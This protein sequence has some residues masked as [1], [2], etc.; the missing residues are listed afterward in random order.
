MTDTSYFHKTVLIFISACIILFTA[1]APII[2]AEEPVALKHDRNTLELKWQERIQS[3]LNTG[4]IP[5]ID[6]ESS[7]KREDGERYIPRAINVM[8]KSGIALIAFDGYQ[9]PKTSKKQKGYRWGY[10]IHHIVNSYPDRFILATNGDTNNN[11]LKQKDSFVDQT[12]EHVKSGNYPIMGEFDFRHYMSNHQCKKGNT[13]RDTNIPI[14]GENA[15]LIFSLSEK[16]GIAFT[17][18]HEPEDRPLAELEEM[19][20]A[21]PKA[22]VIWA[23]FGQIRFPKNETR[24]N[25][26]LVRRLLSSY[27][28]LYFDISTGQPG[29]SYKCNSNVLDTVIW[30]KNS[31]GS[32]KDTL[33]PEYKDIL[34]EFSTRFVVGTDY[35]G[36]R[37]PL[38]DFLKKRVKNARLIMRD[39]TEEA[40]HNISYRNAWFLL[41]GKE[42]VKTTPPKA[43]QLH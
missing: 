42:W 22:K 35:G 29:R 33:K 34:N 26:E 8:D 10:Y 9:A 16:M 4:V 13:K 7:L 21:Y 12:G 19:L 5:L 39:L 3:F 36:G 41:T 27:P 37:S 25:P 28:G 17:I 20:A 31:F 40:K 14:N 43:N 23:H 24:F 6:L 38:P 18:H 30:N 11:W 15:H 32:Q 1:T 2:S